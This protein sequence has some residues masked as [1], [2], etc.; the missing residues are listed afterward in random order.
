MGK[1]VELFGGAITANYPE[2]YI[3]ASYVVHLSPVLISLSTFPTLAAQEFS[4]DSQHTGS[5]PLP[6]FQRQHHLRDTQESPS[7]RLFRRGKV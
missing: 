2:G 3:D 7:Q 5:L 1:L 6:K 4:S